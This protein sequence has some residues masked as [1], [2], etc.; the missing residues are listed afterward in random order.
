MFGSVRPIF[1]DFY[2]IVRFGLPNSSAKF[3]PNS[4]VRFGSAKFE[5]GKVRFGSAQKIRVRFTTK[6]SNQR[7]FPNQSM[8]NFSYLEWL[9]LKSPKVNP[10]YFW[11]VCQITYTTYSCSVWYSLQDWV[12]KLP[13]FRWLE[14]FRATE[15]HPAE[16][17]HET[18]S[19]PIFYC[20]KKKLTKKVGNDSDLAVFLKITPKK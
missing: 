10:H 7:S 11:K 4:S 6:T 3:W 9:D 13:W 18:F 15:K 14:V 16:N 8:C 12:G 17:H 20:P 19:G 2:L 1:S 5:I